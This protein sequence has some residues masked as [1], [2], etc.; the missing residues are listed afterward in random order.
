MSRFCILYWSTTNESCTVLTDIAGQEA[1]WRKV[2]ALKSHGSMRKCY[3]CPNE[4][5][6]P[7][8]RSKTILEGGLGKTGTRGKEKH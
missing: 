5:L 7:K 2:E 4:C 3:P 6:K 8:C 1:T